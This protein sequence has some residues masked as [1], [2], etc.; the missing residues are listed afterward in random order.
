[1]N[2]KNSSG[3]NVFLHANIS[4]KADTAKLLSEMAFDMGISIDDLLSCLAEDAV[5]D[6]TSLPGNQ[7]G[8]FIPDKCSKEDLLRALE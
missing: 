8:I 2:E 3:S 5:F 1:M 7:E 6:L 4:I